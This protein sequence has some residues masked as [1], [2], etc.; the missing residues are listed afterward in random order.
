LKAAA[1][2][3]E[4]AMLEPGLDRHLWQSW[5]EQFDE[6]V[7]TSPAEALSELDG[8]ILQMLEARGYALR[9]PVVAEGDDRDIAAEYG[10]AHEITQAVE[11]GKNVEKEDVDRAIANYRDLYE[12]LIEE[13]AAP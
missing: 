3:K 12:Y 5:W 9:D 13:R 11:A 1:N 8:L 2:A 10:A 7:Q 4:E 6:D